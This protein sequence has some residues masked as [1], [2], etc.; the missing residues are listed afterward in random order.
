M[1]IKTVWLEIVTVRGLLNDIEILP[2]SASIVETLR[3]EIE[4]TREY[5]P[6]SV[7][8]DGSDYWLFDGYHRLEAMKLLGF[9]ACWVRVY[10]GSR[11]DA[12]RR[13][14]RDKLK[15]KG[16]GNRLVF[17]HCLRVL[18]EDPEWSHASSNDLSRLFGRKPAFFET[19]RE[20]QSQQPSSRRVGFCVNKHGSISLF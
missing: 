20:H 16:Q 12:L 15:S 2:S 13:Y 10:R 6:L 14:I 9:N 17:K 18:S 7:C 11:R 1:K 19:L 8:F 5:E 4:A 3:Q